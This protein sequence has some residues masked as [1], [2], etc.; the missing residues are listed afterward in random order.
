MIIAYSSYERKLLARIMRA[1][2]LSDGNLGMLMVGN[3][4]INRALVD[5]FT[6]KDVKTISSVIYQE[7]QF[8][9]TESPLFLSYPTKKELELAD[10]ILKGKYYYPATNSL[11]FYAPKS[12]DC[13]EIR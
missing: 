7:S 10:K 1:E 5:C 6:F 12:G 9:G 8:A 4:V 13:R 3:V 11:W 2:A